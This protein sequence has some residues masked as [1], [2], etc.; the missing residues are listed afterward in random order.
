MTSAEK[1][2]I[3]KKYLIELMGGKCH[4]CGGVFPQCCYH[5]DH[6]D[7]F[8]KVFNLSDHMHWH[9]ERIREEFEKCDMVCANCHAVRTHV[10][11]NM[12]AKQGM[13][14][15]GKKRSAEVRIR[16][17]EAQKGHPGHKHTPETRAKMS[18]SH[19]ARWRRLKVVA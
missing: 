5:F 6:R 10:H 17:S 11:K 4:D 13:N 12:R 2:R 15:K 1:A 3:N 14:Q 18:V 8:A 7:P 19:F 9:F 16:M